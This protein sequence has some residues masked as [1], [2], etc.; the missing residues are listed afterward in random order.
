LKPGDKIK[1]VQWTTDDETVKEQVSAMYGS[2]FDKVK[3]LS[4]DTYSWPYVHGRLQED[5][6]KLE[7]RLIADRDG[8][9]IKT[10]PLTAVDYA[11]FYTLRRGLRPT[12]YEKVHTADSF[13]N[14]VAL[15][16]RETKEKIFEVFGVLRALVTGRLQ[17]RN[18]VGPVGIAAVAGAEASRGVP[19]LLLFLTLLS[20]N[21]AILN[22]LPIPALDGGH[23]MFLLAEAVTGKPVDE[24]I[25]G[26][27]TLIGVVCLLGLMIFVVSNDIGTW[28]LFR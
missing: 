17:A 10:D 20:A 16:F 28:F 11:G 23:M 12:T 3:T 9:E 22:F 6:P 2:Q 14:A 25:Q 18:L 15:G 13:A 26:T 4:D 21:L 8:K 1:A 19:R 7:L 27:L 5:P 24:R